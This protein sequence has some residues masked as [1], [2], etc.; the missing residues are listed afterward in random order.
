[1]LAFSQAE[2]KL[3]LR[4]S[5]LDLKD[6]DHTLHYSILIHNNDLYNGPVLSAWMR[7]GG[8]ELISQTSHYVA[9]MP[10]LFAGDATNRQQ[11]HAAEQAQRSW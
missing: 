9:Q 2:S 5:R 11:L 4:S 10:V 6:N 7:S 1:M 8:L 3:P